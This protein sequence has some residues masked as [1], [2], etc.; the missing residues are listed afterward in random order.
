MEGFYGYDED[1]IIDEMIYDGH[2]DAMREVIGVT[3]DSATATV[4][5]RPHL[6]L[7][8]SLWANT[9]SYHEPQNVI[10]AY[11]E[12]VDARKSADE[13]RLSRTNAWQPD[14]LGPIYCLMR[15]GIVDLWHA[16]ILPHLSEFDW[17][18]LSRTCRDF[19]GIIR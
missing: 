10:Q 7:P 9:W 4:L 16:L 1:E 11:R 17:V 12:A 6:E 3:P 5:F 8:K 18:A 2:Y 14:T 15:R 13:R 19:H